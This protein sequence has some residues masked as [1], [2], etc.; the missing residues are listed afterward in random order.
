MGSKIHNVV[1]QKMNNPDGNNTRDVWY[2]L[3]F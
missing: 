1:D 2:K 3:F